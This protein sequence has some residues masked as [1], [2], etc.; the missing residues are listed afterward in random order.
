MWKL[1][2]LLG[3]FLCFIEF[4]F[5]GQREHLKLSS[6]R[7][8]I[9]QVEH[10]LKALVSH[11]SSPYRW[12]KGKHSV[13]SKNIL[14]TFLHLCVHL[15]H[16]GRCRVRSRFSRRAASSILSPWRWPRWGWE[17]LC[18]APGGCQRESSWSGQTPERSHLFTGSVSAVHATCVCERQRKSAEEECVYVCGCVCVVLEGKSKCPRRKM[19]VGHQH[20][21][22]VKL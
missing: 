14:T 21:A 18:T 10:S 12:L 15:V 22:C 8:I 19:W 20:V 2:H 17:C 6:A 13:R 16:R 5:I 1:K 11:Y 4:N 9:T 3:P 7:W